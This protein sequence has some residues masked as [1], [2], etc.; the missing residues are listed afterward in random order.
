MGWRAGLPQWRFI[1]K[2]LARQMRHEPTPAEAM[3][4]RHVRGRNVSGM[5]FRRQHAI[6]RYIVDFY[7]PEQRLVVELDGTSHSARADI[8]S[9]RDQYLRDRGERVL[10]LCNEKVMHDIDAVLATIAAMLRV[11]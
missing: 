9:L 5:R 1:S 2:Q 4:W 6:G 8:D 7:C 3:L 10:R 11:R